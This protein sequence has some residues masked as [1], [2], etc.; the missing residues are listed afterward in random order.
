MTEGIEYT[1]LYLYWVEEWLYRSQ[2]IKKNQVNQLQ[3]PQ[4][5]NN[6]SKSFNS[7]PLTTSLSHCY[8]STLSHCYQYI[9]PLCPTITILSVTGPFAL[10]EAQPVRAMMLK[11]L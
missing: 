5:S 4:D 6:A 11:L 7:T 9:Y 10:G 3:Y 8:Q 1:E 2:H